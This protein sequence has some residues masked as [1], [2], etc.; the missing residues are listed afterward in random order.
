M[1]RYV[2]MCL[3]KI[4]CLNS[5]EMKKFYLFL[6]T[7][8][9]IGQA[10]SQTITNGVSVLTVTKGTQTP[11][12]I[13]ITFTLTMA[14]AVASFYSCNFLINHGMLSNPTLISTTSP[15]VHY[16]SNITTMGGLVLN[17]DVDD[18]PNAITASI[19]SWT[20]N[21]STSGTS[22]LCFSLGAVNEC[23]NTNFDE[24]P[25]TI[26]YCNIVL[27]AELMGFQAQSKGKT[28]LLTWQTASEKNNKGFFIERSA[29]AK[30][31]ETIGFV[32]GFGTTTQTQS[33]VFN[34]NTPL[35]IAYYRVRQEDKDGAI[36][37][38]KTLSVAT[39][40]KMTVKMYPN[41]A[42]DRVAIENFNGFKSLTITSLQGISLVKT[43]LTEADISNL[44]A[45]FYILEVE[46]T[47]GSVSRM[48]FIKK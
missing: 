6:Y 15:S 18:V 24:F 39:S 7:I 19:V 38:S 28:N 29:D 45:G 35:S 10:N 9:W 11:T 42:Q 23:L 21:F 17:C 27:P 26:D 33:Y 14:P 13:D 47:E 41:P 46:N 12:T 3:N 40:S 30:K 36:L 43:Q 4:L 37:Y 34:D 5:I 31:F 16:V 22:T 25:A 20:V 32:K 44:S 8:L 1:C 2:A 48:T